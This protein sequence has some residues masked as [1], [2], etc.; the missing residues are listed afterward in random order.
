ML[1]NSAARL[2]DIHPLTAPNWYG[3]APVGS[4]RF[5]GR[6]KEMWEVHSLLAAS[7]V[8]QITGATVNIGQLRGMGGVGKSLLAEEYA[9]HFGA[10]YP[11]GVF[12]LRAYGNDDAKLLAPTRSRSNSSSESLSDSSLRPEQQ[13]NLS[14][15]VQTDSPLSSE[16]RPN[17]STADPTESPQ[18]S[19]EAATFELAAG[20][21]PR[22]S[23]GTT[24]PL[25]G[26]TLG[27]EAREA[28]RAD[29]MRAMADRLGIDTQGLTAEQIQ[30][31]LSRKI[32]TENKSCLW[33]VDDVPNG[34]DGEA[35]RRWFAPH[36]LARTL[37]TT[38]SREYGSLAK[39][40]D[41]SVLTPDEA[42][43]L[44]TARRKPAGT[45]EEA[46][47][48]ALANDLGYHAL[49]LDVTASALMSSVAAEPFRDFRAKLARPDKDALALA[50]TLADALPNGHEKSIAQT[51]L[52]SIRGLGAEGLDFLLLA[53]VLAVAPIP[54]SLVTAVFEKADKLSH[55]DA[56][57]RTSLAFKQV[58]SASLAENAGENQNARS[59]HT[60]VS[61]AVRF[62][63]KSTPER[64]QTLR[65][66]AV[67]GLRV[68]IAKVATDPRIRGG[69]SELHTA[70]ARQLVARA[71]NVNEGNL[72]GWLARYD[73]ERGSYVSARLLRTHELEFRSQAQGEE[74]PATLTAR[75]NLA[76]TLHAQGDLAGAR[77]QFEQVLEASR[78]LLGEEHPTTLTARLNLA[79]T[80]HAQGDL[81]A[82][83]T[84]KSRC[85]RPVGGC[86][87]R[88]IPTP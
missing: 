77:Q 3:M 38:R 85:W 78:R 57:E 10:A 67:E 51:M 30:G 1:A 62:Q 61:R 17:L 83:G 43:Q 80:L 28:L 16:A 52:R 8:T 53:S 31:A 69:E 35:L 33:V 48:R 40:I 47:A 7:D 74:H 46:Q 45:N 39:G 60:L 86:W 79:A 59:V 32:A 12:W 73:D 44:L 58:T 49:A 18:T 27:S 21:S 9:L 87:A 24:E 56:E 64:T 41:L 36:A 25:S 29:Q 13:S 6:L 68:K 5:V 54:A 15:R 72:L 20:V 71:A 82:R 22:S 37:I 55:E 81:A 19:R 42:Y 34:L 50:E 84:T 63:G 23:A 4:T 11:G 14:S 2:A 75:L 88:N 76:A 26:D 65:A 70:H 66:A